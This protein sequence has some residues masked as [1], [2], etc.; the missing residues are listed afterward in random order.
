MASA[1]ELVIAFTMGLTGSFTWALSGFID[2]R[3]VVIIMAGSLIGIQIG[4]VGTTYVKDYMI[5]YVMSSVMLIVAVSRAFAIPP[6][7]HDLGVMQL[8][9]STIH[10]MKNVSFVTLCV[11]LAAGGLIVLGSMFKKR[12]EIRAEEQAQVLQHS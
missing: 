10:L 9:G 7:L 1:S 2:I 5:K 8:T 4:A 3:M 11:A 6:Y 12:K